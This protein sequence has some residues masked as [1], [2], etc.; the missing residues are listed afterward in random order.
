MNRMLNND[1][2]LDEIVEQFGIEVSASAKV[3]K[4]SKKTTK[5]Q[6]KNS[7]YRG[8]AANEKSQEILKKLELSNKLDPTGAYDKL[9]S[10]ITLKYNPDRI[11]SFEEEL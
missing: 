6:D 7:G 3:E 9:V 1:Q 10:R 11:I 2:L 4:T 5:N 8:K